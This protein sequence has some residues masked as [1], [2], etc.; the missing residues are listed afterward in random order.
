M[1]II[2]F[3]IIM[4]TLFSC[5]SV[6][7]KSVDKLYYRFGEAPVT[8]SESNFLVQR[9]VAMGILGNRP[10]IAQNSDGA[11]V[12]L[13]HNFWLDSPK[14]LLQNYLLQSFNVTPDRHENVLKTTIL[15]LEKK[16]ASSLLTITFTLVDD[17]NEVL[18]QKT[19]KKQQTLTQNTIPAFVR[20]ISESLKYIVKQLASDLK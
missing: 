14:I 10:M 12:Q 11:L 17:N 5:T 9:P 3:L 2:L 6:G 16:G 19:Y 7:K 4:L 13:N 8:A 18:F 1:K 15:N 20:S